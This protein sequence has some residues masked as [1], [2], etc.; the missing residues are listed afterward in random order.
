VTTILDE[1][2]PDPHCGRSSDTCLKFQVGDQQWS[3]RWGRY[4]AFGTPAYW[5][6]QTVRCHYA[7]RVG[8]LAAG[9]LETEVVFCLLGGFGVTAE[10]AAAAHARIAPLLAATELPEASEIE[11]VLRE[12]LSPSGA[13]YRFPRQRS[14]RIAAAIRAVR[15]EPVPT[16][17]SSLRRHLLRLPG[18]GPKTAAWIV[19]NYTG[20]DEVAIIDI[21]LVRML[22]RNGVFPSEWDVRRD[23]PRYEEA[24]LSYAAQGSVRPAALDLCIWQQARRTGAQMPW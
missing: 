8:G 16:D 10:S 14:T 15:E 23:Y 9:D 24:F 22:S 7:E 20:S 13:R 12:P 1:P 3:T 11:A 19:R 6:D 5:V 18:V 17:A 4:D 2:V 21:W